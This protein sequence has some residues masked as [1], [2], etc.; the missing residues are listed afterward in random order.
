M[1][2]IESCKMGLYI[3]FFWGMTWRLCVAFQ[4]LFLYQV[5]AGFGEN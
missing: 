1:S 5:A 3:A 2:M 4:H